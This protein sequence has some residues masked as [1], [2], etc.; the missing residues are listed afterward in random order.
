MAEAVQ[1]RVARER[2]HPGPKQY[3]GVAIVLAVITLVEV[4]LF[5]VE[6]PDVA[7]VAGLVTLSAVKFGMVVGW[8]MHLRFDSV[9]FR[10]LFITGL[11]L[12]M[13]VYLAALLM[14]GLRP[15][16]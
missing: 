10:R 16:D 15:V 13:G 12:A 8:F 2:P 5:Y 4:I 6:M 14:L 3:V 7:L 9:L 1:E 11:A